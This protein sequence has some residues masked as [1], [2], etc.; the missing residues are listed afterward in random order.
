ME[1]VDPRIHIDLAA[2]DIDLLGTAPYLK[3]RL[4]KVQV[5]TRC[6]LPYIKETEVR[7][8]SSSQDCHKI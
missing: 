4:R 7:K 2:V 8:E 6:I 3:K 1:E 5:E